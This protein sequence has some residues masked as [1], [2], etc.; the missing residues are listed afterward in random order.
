M[1]LYARNDLQFIA[2]PSEAEAAEI[3][4]AGPSEPE[5]QTR[6]GS[7]TALSVNHT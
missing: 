4:T 2:I 1:T 3:R 7:L 6:S 5:P